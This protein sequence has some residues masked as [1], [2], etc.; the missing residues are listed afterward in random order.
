MDAFRGPAMGI[1]IV[2]V[3]F[4]MDLVFLFSDICYT[5]IPESFQFKFQI[6]FF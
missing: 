4:E 1:V 2:L 6:I 3:V 5:F